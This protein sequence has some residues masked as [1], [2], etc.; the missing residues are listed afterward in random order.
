MVSGSQ[1]EE[2]PPGYEEIDPFAVATLDFHFRYEKAVLQ[3]R[4]G[5]VVQSREV[6][7]L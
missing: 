7:V 3:S 2:M 4:S 5:W 1:G 6:E